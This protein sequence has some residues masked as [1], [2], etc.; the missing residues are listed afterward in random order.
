MKRERLKVK[1]YLAKKGLAQPLAIFLH[2]LGVVLLTTLFL[3]YIYCWRSTQQLTISFIHL[4]LEVDQECGQ[5]TQLCLTE[6][7]MAGIC[8]M[9]EIVCLVV[10]EAHRATGNYSYCVVIRE[11]RCSQPPIFFFH[12]V[13]ENVSVY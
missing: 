2:S 1:K 4:L 3:L 6:R 12:C 9:K 13:N 5:R 11:V 8:P 10:D 7:K